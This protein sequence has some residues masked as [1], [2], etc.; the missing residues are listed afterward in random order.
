MTLLAFEAVTRAGSA[1]IVA[2]DGS[3]PAHVAIAPGR[4]AAELPRVLDE[5]LRAHA[6][7][8]L[9]VAVGPGSFTGLRVAVVAARTLAWTDDLPVHPVDSMQAIAAT[10]GPGLWWVLLP[11]KKD[12]T[13]HACYRV[14]DE[15]C[16]VI[17]AIAACD[18][19]VTPELVPA[20]RE[21]TA[22]GPALAA[23]PGLA[24]RWC[25]GIPV[26]EAIACDARGV[27][28]AA[29]WTPAVPGGD[30]RPAYHMASAPEL[31]REARGGVA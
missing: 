24:E 17:A 11:L 16:T 27:A 5:L 8:R 3:E 1:C 25:P 15:G 14:T 13:F 28:R 7:D 9:A 4:A 20:V 26:G 30:L 2:D 12:V 22:I 29:A 21:A 18:D 6:P 19:A 31:E 23:K 10:A